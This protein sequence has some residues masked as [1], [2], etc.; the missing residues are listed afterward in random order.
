MGGKL[1]ELK[2]LKRNRG[3]NLLL[4]ALAQPE[5]S[6]EGQLGQIKLAYRLYPLFP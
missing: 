6:H 1:H 4:F 2:F 3:N 5:I